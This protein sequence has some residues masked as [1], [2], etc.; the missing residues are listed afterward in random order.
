MGSGTL[1]AT[2]YRCSS[3]KQS[4]LA[5]DFHKN[6]NRHTG[7]AQSCKKCQKKASADYYK[8]NRV[9]ILERTTYYQKVNSKT[10]SKYKRNW[11]LQKQYRISQVDY[12]KLFK[13][14]HGL[15]AICHEPETKINSKTKN[16]QPLCVDHDHQTG[17]IRGLLCCKHNRTI[18][19]L[20]DDLRSLEMVTDYLRVNNV[21]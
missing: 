6:K 19:L 4:K 2:Y 10:R 3:C 15:C 20:G 14:Q 17:R 8:R 12:D 5:E 1:S 7:L 21:I 13:A 9:A 11:H 16:I 18:G